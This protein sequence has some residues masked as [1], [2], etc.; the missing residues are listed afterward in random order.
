MI[1]ILALVLLASTAFADATRPKAFFSPKGGSTD[2]LVALVDGAKK[3]V[4]VMAFSFTS[5]RVADALSRAKARGVD[6]RAVIDGPQRGGKYTVDIAGVDEL[7][8]DAHAI[9]HVK[10]MV[11]DEEIVQVGS[12]NYTDGAEKRNSEAFVIL[13]DKAL[14]GEFIANWEK[15]A[16]HSKANPTARKRKHK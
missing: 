12:F 11:V 15:H 3:Q 9:Q 8:D 16:A 2:A 6:V 13:R 7:W 14:A 1:R 4:L 5:R 10:S